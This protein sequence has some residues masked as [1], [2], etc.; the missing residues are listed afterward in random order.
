[1]TITPNCLIL[2]AFSSLLASAGCSSA[3]PLSPWEQSPDPQRIEERVISAMGTDF[4]IQIWTEHSDP[5]SRAQA[6]QAATAELKR[7]A[8]IA[9]PND[10]KSEVSQVNLK[11]QKAAVRVSPELMALLNLGFQVGAR[12]GGVFDVT[13]VSIQDA[14]EKH[15]E[16]T[17]LGS[18]VNDAADDVSH[19][20][21]TS[22][23]S[24]NLV[25]NAAASQVRFARPGVKIGILGLAKGYAIQKAA[26]K[27]QSMRLA[28]FALIG[29]HVLAASGKALSDPRL[30]CV[31]HPNQLGTCAYKVTLTSNMPIAYLAT[32]ALELRP[33]HIY[34]AKNG[35]RKARSGGATLIASDGASVQ[36]AATA[37]SAMD[38]PA[39]QR[40]LDS[41]LPPKISGVFFDSDFD[42]RTHGSLDPFAKITPAM[43]SVPK[44]AMPEPKAE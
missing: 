28:G 33:G 18:G 39:T 29:G 37:I 27:L 24:K 35:L 44:S 21:K 12:S 43:A 13:F 6:F 16:D 2:V 38:N 40:F 32:S 31:E 17:G 30:M 5:R 4:H 41:A 23:G 8:R 3:P 10:P 9:D 25:I 42:I 15:G 19:A 14:T 20:L 11:A 1:M 22:V 34:N 7:V 36:A 26:E